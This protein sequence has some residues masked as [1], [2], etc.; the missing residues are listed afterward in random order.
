MYKPSP[1]E[2][3]ALLLRALEERG[4]RRGRPLT[5]ARLSRLTLRDLWNR[6]QLDEAWLREI[7]EWLLSAGWVLIAAGPT[8][9][10]VKTEVIENW[11]RVASKHIKQDLDRVNRGSFDFSELEPLL[12]AVPRTQPMTA[13]PANP[14]RSRKS[15]T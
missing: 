8:C 6:Q 4:E 3:A 11:P 9:G 13:T 15:R 1:R 2:S 14:K 5:R 12:Q 10:V 7:N